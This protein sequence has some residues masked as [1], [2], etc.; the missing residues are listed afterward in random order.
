[1]KKI[2]V[3]SVFIASLICYS[4]STTTQVNIN[5]SASP[6]STSSGASVSPSDMPSTAPSSDT[7]PSPSVSAPASTTPVT[8]NCIEP[9]VGQTY[10]VTFFANYCPPPVKVGTKWV[11]ST[12][13]AGT[14]AE[15]STE[16]LAIQGNNYTVRTKGPNIDRTDTSTYLGYQD[17]KSDTKF[18]YQGKE[19]VS[20]KAGSYP[21]SAKLTTSST[22]NGYTTNLTYWVAKNVGVVKVKTDTATPI[23]NI[24]AIVELSS[25]TP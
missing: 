9:V 10:D 22:A 6:S 25:F 1:M 15:V 4:C 2:N 21:G 3:L 18:V 12:T 17:I 20:V 24:S 16:I 13:A 7:T 14:S 5:P 11:Y 23:G 19:D 8:S